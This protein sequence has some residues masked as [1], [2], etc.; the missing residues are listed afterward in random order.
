MLKVEGMPPMRPHTL[1]ESLEV[2]A[3][4]EPWQRRFAAEPGSRSLPFVYLSDEWYYN[5]RRPF[6]PA[7]HYGGYAQ[8]ENGVRMTRK[9]LEDWRRARSTLPAEIGPTRKVALVTSVMAAPTIE[10]L[11]RDLGA[12]AGLEVRVLPVVNRFWGELV[13][14]A[15]LLCAQDVLDALRDRCNDFASDDLIL[16]PRVMLDTA[17]V[18][19]LD[20]V[21]VEDFAARVP[22]RVQFVKD[23]SA[24]AGAIRTLSLAAAPVA[25]L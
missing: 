16:L 3:R 19:F 24:L 15:G 18:R 21:T 14:V 12:V 22:A 4:V 7:R 20:D 25:A 6:P 10:R 9:L 17:G 1:A 11:A 2:M 5:T 8:I 23:A 13:T